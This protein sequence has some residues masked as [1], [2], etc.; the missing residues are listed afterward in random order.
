MTTITSHSDQYDKNIFSLYVDYFAETFNAFARALSSSTQFNIVLSK[1]FSQ[2]YPVYLNTISEYNKSW[3]D[4]S[5]LDKVLRSRYRKAFDEKFR[6]VDFINRLSDIITSYSELAKITGL[7]QMYRDFSNG[8]SIWNNKFI[9]PIRDTLYRT[10]S[11]KIC[12]IEKYSLFHYKGPSTTTSTISAAEEGGISINQ[13]AATTPVLIIYAFINRHYIL[14]LLPEVSVVQSL[15]NQGLDIF[16]AD[17]GTP[18]TYDKSLTIGHFV[19]SYLDKSIDLMRKITKSDKVSL[20]GY[21][22]GGDLALMYASIH[23]EKVKN[24]VTI[25]TPGDFDLDN[26]LLAIWTKA[27]KEDLLLDT[28]GN[29]P[30]ILLNAAF[31]LRNPIEYGH[32][33]FHF[34]EQP[35]SFESVAQFFATETWLND[36]PPI[37]GE[38]Y[39]EFVEYC[40][41][42]NLFIKNKMRIGEGYNEIN[43]DAVVNLKNIDMSF[44][45]I[46]A[47]KD[48]LIA[49]SSSKALNDA[50]TESNDKSII[51]LNSGHVGLMIGKDAHK[52]LWP[53]VGRWLRE[54][55]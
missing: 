44:L 37:I 23:P 10:T 7:G 55:S 36:S 19:N 38:I 54:R 30:G 26:S 9:E 35:R 47:K 45:N 33:Y 31:I 24:L 39:R 50:L 16:A 51:E 48:D 17:W 27:M 43:F 11:E 1:A 14:D 25:A 34:F 22:W 46:I 42:Q 13:K 40:Y 4:L 32:K 41:K 2:S 3:K 28:F 5:E 20:F 21:C 12:E 15:L 8:S 29:L 53:K 6:D 18:S 52:E 49:P